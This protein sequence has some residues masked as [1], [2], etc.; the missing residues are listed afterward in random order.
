MRMLQA[1]CCTNLV[2]D[3]SEVDVARLPMNSTV[4]FGRGLLVVTGCHVSS[5][6]AN[7]GEF[8]RWCRLVV[9]LGIIVTATCR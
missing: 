3:S 6:S 7:L 2:E 9:L 8:G 5:L 4:L 1:L